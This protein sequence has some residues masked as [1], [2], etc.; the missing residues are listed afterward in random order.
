MKRQTFKRNLESLE[1]IYSFTA[2]FFS[3]HEVDPGLLPA[4]DLI[5]EELF[6]N[7]VEHSTESD[8]D[9]PMEIK[10]VESGVEVMLTDQDVDPFDITKVPEVDIDR[11]VEELDAGGLGLHLV[12]QFAD[13]VEYKYESDKRRSRII[14]KKTSSGR[15]GSN[16][17]ED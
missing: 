15:S 7:I 1:S 3:E 4:V 8:A 5:V 6:T 17:A 12:K 9:V 13:S 16:Q 2:E 11:S 14:F 10:A